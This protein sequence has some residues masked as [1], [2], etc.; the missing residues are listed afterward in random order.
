M[1]QE[2]RT[3]QETSWW[4]LEKDQ[5]TIISSSWQLLL[6]GG[7]TLSIANSGS[8]GDFMPTTSVR[9]PG[10]AALLNPRGLESSKHSV[11]APVVGDPT[12]ANVPLDLLLKEINW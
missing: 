9:Q 11:S 8:Q 7:R 12:R 3:T 4:A 10:K 2:D 6:I 1:D 5:P